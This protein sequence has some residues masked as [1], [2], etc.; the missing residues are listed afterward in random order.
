M[1]APKFV[2]VSPT[3][4]PRVYQSPENIPD[5]WRADRPAELPGRQPQG[6]SLGYQGPDQGF[7][8]TIAERVAD[9]DAPARRASG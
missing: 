2:P 3:D 5:A 9:D 6:A 7:A 1:A 8:L 4:T